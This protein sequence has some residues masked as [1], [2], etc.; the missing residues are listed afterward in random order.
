MCPF[1]T[2]ISNSPFTLKGTVVNGTSCV[3]AVLEFL[4]RQQG[5]IWGLSANGG[6]E[7]WQRSAP[8]SAFVHHSVAAPE[9]PASSL[10]EVGGTWV[11]LLVGAKGLGFG[12]S[13]SLRNCPNLGPGG[14]RL[15][16]LLLHGDPILPHPVNLPC[17]LQRRTHLI[18]IWFEEKNCPSGQS[19]CKAFFRT[20]FRWDPSS[21]SRISA[22]AVN[23]HLCVGSSQG[24]TAEKCESAF[25]ILIQRQQTATW[26]VVLTS[27]C[28]VWLSED[29]LPGSKAVFYIWII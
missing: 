14:Q 28:S 25:W 18:R 3:I 5:I 15:A 8:A 7:P 4:S 9:L 1:Q 11:S 13:G 12:G 23:T 21:S 6:Q 19:C 26:W 29:W 20:L 22:H 16:W 27:D 10:S 17:P 24:G 2:V